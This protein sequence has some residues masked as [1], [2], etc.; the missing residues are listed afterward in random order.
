MPA[1]V[2]SNTSD[3]MQVLVL[4]HGGAMARE[5]LRLCKENGLSGQ[6]LLLSS[7]SLE[8]KLQEFAQRPVYKLVLI[9]LKQ[10]FEPSIKNALN[11][12]KS[13][14]WP[15]LYIGH[16]KSDYGADRQLQLLDLITK[17]RESSG[18]RIVSL[19]S[20]KTAT[21]AD[22]Q[23]TLYPLVEESVFPLLPEFLF[24]PNTAPKRI[25]SGK[26]VLSSS[27]LSFLPG[28]YSVSPEKPG[29]K[30]AM[31]VPEKLLEQLL[32]KTRLL[33]ERFIQLV[34]SSVAEQAPPKK[35]I[36]SKS[37]TLVKK[38]SKKP[39]KKASF[40]AEVREL[41]KVEQREEKQ[42]SAQKKLS[43][44][45]RIVAKNRRK[46]LLLFL[47]SF[48][49]GFAAA[50]TILSLSFFLSLGR[51]EQ[52]KW[53]KIFLWQYQAIKPLLTTGF[54]DKTEKRL[55]EIEHQ[56]IL[57]VQKNELTRLAS[58]LLQSFFNQE[59]SKPELIP[60][61]QAL[62]ARHTAFET[63]DDNSPVS[64]LVEKLPSLLASENKKTYLVL[65]Q[66]E[67]E[68]RPSGGLVESV[69]FI[70]IED[71]RL[72]DSK[73]FD[74]FTL[75]RALKGEL[76]APADFKDV[77]GLESL[78]LREANWDP[79]FPSAARQIQK[80]IKT[81]LGVQVDGVFA[82][83]LE[84]LAH[85]LSALGPVGI[86]DEREIVTADTLSDQAFSHYELQLVERLDSSLFLTE[87]ARAL[88]E[89]L[90]KLSVSQS[91]SLLVELE[92]AA[93]SGALFFADLSSSPL[94]SW[95][96]AIVTPSCPG[97]TVAKSTES[98][99]IDYFALYESNVGANKLN[100]ELEQEMD[101]L[102]VLKRGFVEHERNI[103]VTNTSNDERQTY[104]GY[105]RFLLPSSARLSSVYIN[106]KKI[107]SKDII[108]LQNHG[109][110]QYGL[111]YSVA[112]GRKSA[113]R[114]QYQTPLPEQ[115][116]EYGFFEQA[117][118]GIFNPLR[119]RVQYSSE[120]E[121]RL[122]APKAEI[123]ESMVIFSEIINTGK[124]FM[125]KF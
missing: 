110:K 9:D 54:T 83:N 123:S 63:T 1:A 92:Q 30:V 106:Q 66:N 2:I 43:S 6:E 27:L 121:P 111:R 36:P 39:E 94:E 80:Q 55:K 7:S 105:M 17:N 61:I 87:L 42:E 64:S 99:H 46:K 112:A 47:S 16:W 24:S 98:C 53:R 108:H 86:A 107:D 85:I 91:R 38:T 97:D 31:Q 118:P 73:V 21:I 75:E 29:K 93:K 102:A 56:E 122:L 78:P 33:E 71:A 113:I 10:G 77:R 103:L 125:I 15:T 5:C 28:N 13:Q 59:L 109:K 4:G 18:E 120:K 70:T 20:S 45:K 11:F 69:I 35:T 79:D 119:L 90:S 37:P 68:L 84:S 81:G 65:L 14:N 89:K 62:F 67:H 19:F 88:L 72:V 22:P 8:Q 117:Q 57:V 26:A 101:H 41:F 60:Q 25:V 76:V 34:R 114:L 74:V 115:V 52:K 44:G 104:H 40:E 82:L 3:T 95:S 49:F 58:E 12:A 32:V 51:L 96:G 48:F 23:T 116:K 124:L 50:T 100:Y